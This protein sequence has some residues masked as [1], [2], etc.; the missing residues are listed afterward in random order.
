MKHDRSDC[1]PFDFEPNGI[2]F[3]SK[4]NRKTVTTTI[5]HSIRKEMEYQ[6]SQCKGKRRTKSLTHHGFSPLEGRSCI[7]SCAI[8]KTMIFK[9]VMQ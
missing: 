3:C 6:F 7:S 2:P 1:F 4:L 8:F 9:K 5:S